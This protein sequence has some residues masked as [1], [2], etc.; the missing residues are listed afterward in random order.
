VKNWFQKLVSKLAFKFNLYR[1]KEGERTTYRLANF[2]HFAFHEDDAPV[3]E[4]AVLQHV[5]RPEVGSCT[6]VECTA[7]E[8]TAVGCTA[9]GCTAVECTAVECTAVECTAVAFS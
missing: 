6:A 9:V 8:C 3:V 4:G 2:D 5:T 7:V 1:Y